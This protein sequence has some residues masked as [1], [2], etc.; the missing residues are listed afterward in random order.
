MGTGKL[1]AAHRCVGISFIIYASGAGV[2][3]LGRSLQP[4]SKTDRS[5]TI[6]QYYLQLYCVGYSLLSSI[7]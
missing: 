4:N 3:V 6:K 1:G 2:Y 5:L 7:P